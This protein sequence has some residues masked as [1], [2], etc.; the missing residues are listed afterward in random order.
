MDKQ[1]ITTGIFVALALLMGT[2]AGFYLDNPETTYYCESK[3]VVGICDKLSKVNSAGIQSRCYFFSEELDKTT[4]KT[5][6]SGWVSFSD[7]FPDY[8]VANLFKVNANGEIYDCQFSKFMDSYS[9]CI[10]ES[11]KEAYLGELI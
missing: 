2:G 10:S 6:S 9:V 1:K 8:Q 4:Y 5:C 11:M 7:K 3:D